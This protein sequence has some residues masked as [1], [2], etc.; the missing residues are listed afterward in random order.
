MI[1]PILYSAYFTLISWIKLQTHIVV[2][3]NVIT[4]MKSA[5]SIGGD[6]TLKARN[7]IAIN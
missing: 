3:Q 2:F 4:D 7:N 5:T 6:I 1:S